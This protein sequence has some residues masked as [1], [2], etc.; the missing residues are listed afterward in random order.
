M[1]N[2]IVD[3]NNMIDI[4]QILNSIKDEQKSLQDKHKNI[5][6]KKL[7]DLA[8]IAQDI[9]LNNIL[10]VGFTPSFN[11]G[12]PCVHKTWVIMHQDEIADYF[13]D[14]ERV[15]VENNLLDDDVN[16]VY[17]FFE[18]LDEYYLVPKYNDYYKILF[19]FSDGK[20]TE[21]YSEYYS[22]Y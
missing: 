6:E 9:G 7:N 3:I 12:D 15:F 10:V 5:L 16:S 2:M 1:K 14:E 11:D 22:D 13:S 21:K 19:T 8:I 4:T 18:A 17:H 20:Y